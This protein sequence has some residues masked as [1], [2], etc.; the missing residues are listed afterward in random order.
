MTTTSTPAAAVP[1]RFPLVEPPGPARI[2][3]VG[4]SPGDQESYFGAPF[5]GPSGGLLKDALNS[6]GIA[7]TQLFLGNLT[8]YQPPR[9]HFDA[10][11]WDGPEIQSG[12]NQLRE[13]LERFR[14]T[15]VL[16]LGNEALHL[17]KHGNVAPPKTKGGYD[18]SS[19]IGSWRG[20][21]FVSC[22]PSGA[23]FKCLAT[24]HPAAVLREFSLQ[25]YYRTGFGGLGDLE[26]LRDEAG[27]SEL[28]LPERE[29]VVWTPEQGLDAALEVL[30]HR[31]QDRLPLAADIEGAPGNVTSIA[32][33]GCPEVADVFPLARADGSSLWNEADEIVLWQAIKELLE[34]PAIVKVTQHGQYDFFALA[35]TYG[36]V[37]RGWQ[38]D[39]EEAWWELAAELRKSLAVQTSLL[40][41][42]PFYK[43]DKEDGE[44]KFASD[45]E[46]WRYNGLDACV[47]FECWQREL[48]LMN[49]GQRAHYR[50][51]C[52][53]F[54]AVLQMMLRGLRWDK[55]RAAAAQDQAQQE[56]MILQAKIDREASAGDTEHDIFKMR[57]AALEYDEPAFVQL[58]ASALCGK[59][60]KQRVEV[61]E[62]RWQPMR[63]NGKR[64]VKDGKATTTKPGA[65]QAQDAEPP[66]WGN[67][68][69][70]F[71]P[72]EKLVAKRVVF[73]PTTLD[74]CEPHVLDSNAA[75]WREVKRVW[76]AIGQNDTKAA[77]ALLAQ[78]STALGIA[79][80]ASSTNQGGDAQRFLY[81]CCGLH[82][83]FVNER[84]DYSRE[85]DSTHFDRQ[86]GEPTTIPAGKKIST[87]QNALDK[88][89]AET[90][91]VRVLWVLQQRRLKKVVT[92][93]DTKLDD[94]DRLR[95]SISLVKE[96]GRMAESAAPTGCGLNRQAL[97]KDLRR[98]C[99]ADE[100]CRLGQLDLEG[101][102]S[103][104]VAAECA[105]LGDLTMLDDLRAGLKPAK[106]LCLL[107][108]LGDDVN[109]WSRDEI[110]RRL[111]ETILPD[112]LYP[113][114]KSSVHGCYTGDHEVL[115]QTGWVPLDVYD[116]KIP[117]MCYEN[118]T[119][120]AF[121]AAPSAFTRFLY[122]GD[123]YSFQGNSLDVSVTE[124]HRFAY[125]TNGHPKVMYARDLFSFRGASIPTAGYFDGGSI[126]VD[127]PQLVAA[128][129]ADGTRAR[130]GTVIFRF[131]KKRK[132]MRMEMLL[133]EAGIPYR[134][135]S[136]GDGTTH[137]T[138]Q[139]KQDS[140]LITRW[141]KAADDYLLTWQASDLLSYVE[142]HAHWD[143]HIHKKGGYS[144]SAVNRSHLDWI[145]TASKF[146]GK[147][148]TWSSTLTSGF[149]STVHRL[150]INNRTYADSDSLYA[151]TKAPVENEPVF[152]PTVPSG[153]IF[154]RRNRKIYVSGNS[155]YGMGLPTMIQT[156]L[157]Y[158]MADLP[159]ELSDAK[160]IVLTRDQA[161]KLQ[162]AFFSRYRGVKL[163]HAK[164]K[165]DLLT[166]GYLE[167]SAGHTRRFYGRKAERRKGVVEANHET[168]KE[169][170]ASGPQ[171][172]TTWMSKR[173][174][175]RLWY[176]ETNRRGNDLI[177]EP[178]LLVHDAM[179][180]QWRREDDAWART[181]LR[182]WFD[183]EVEIAGQ[184][185]TIP[186][187]GQVDDDWS[188]KK[189]EKL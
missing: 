163:W 165:R 189:G 135:V 187:D 26:R 43:P 91:D 94:D 83:I 131:K 7:W 183:N 9:N 140:N 20:S 68:R 75:A 1:N 35:W 101:A 166:K 119:R 149:G 59:N 104:T 65:G 179:V 113:G 181:K 97:N 93:L 51:N 153:F 27:T 15:I 109:R 134:K 132:I 11:D 105:A 188:M 162:D 58:V 88:L 25:A 10:L 48:E 152:C 112:W 89:Y 61:V 6:V 53:L 21:L 143:G 136:Y 160:P 86:A 90:Q 142:E 148:Y 141:G 155:S 42:E 120:R 33:A 85:A 121:F 164:A 171:F 127:Y 23:A 137:L 138:V 57:H 175:W 64:W 184:K 80:N 176:D 4:Q 125:S 17:F 107:Y 185:V 146:V 100:G 111:K 129:Q 19:K 13:D 54:P 39:T 130:S 145:A 76:K 170:L 12:I 172:Y 5:V 158:S 147:G 22:W 178:L 159:L 31:R 73:V 161:K 72:T 102:D 40:T 186:A 123:L 8:Q 103:W 150:K 32:F 139:D 177:V 3:V 50:F 115:T 114:A 81:D 87:D 29:I 82:R 66:L 71:K 60:P 98:V 180:G 69:T 167:T 16:C 151:K 156:V 174:L 168:F 124:D 96:T 133:N 117:I 46:F 154:V 157:K 24:W 38:H 67:V 118:E 108:L 70:W 92:D 56:A 74:D 122:T 28:R 41:R 37:V 36:I 77:D 169:A 63:W 126:E 128:Y 182:E 173:A 78:L 116:S 106:V 44:L 34:D 30:A 62:P 52:E 84:G 2:A 110:K 55:D 14:P 95:A 49:D 45:A 47:T 144:L 18:W 99:V 79:I